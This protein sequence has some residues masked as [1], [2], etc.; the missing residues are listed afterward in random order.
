MEK[1][2]ELIRIEF[3][4]F[5]PKE[6]I[7]D[8][9]DG[10]YWND[11]LYVCLLDLEGDVP[12]LYLEKTKKNGKIVRVFNKLTEA[13]AYAAMV[14]ESEKVESIFIKKW[15]IKFLDLIEY[16]NEVSKKYKDKEKN[17]LKIVAS[18][19]HDQKLIELDILWTDVNTF[20]N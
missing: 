5:V 4:N 14:A 2:P 12:R 15:E 7:I 13:N 19:I 8:Y 16:L 1:H 6:V 18:G 11:N 20:I 3:K 9:F 17:G 10:L